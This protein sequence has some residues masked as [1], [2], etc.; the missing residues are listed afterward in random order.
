MNVQHDEGWTK[1]GKES[2]LKF[3]P[4]QYVGKP[5][6]EIGESGA[7]GKGTGIKHDS[8]KP[9]Y[10]LLPPNALHE[11]VRTLTA[12]A[13]KYDS[14]DLSI[15]PNWKKVDNPQRR[16]FAASQRH[17]WAY[18]R[19]EAYDVGEGGSDCHHLAAA[20]TNLMFLLERELTKTN[21]G[22]QQ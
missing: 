9:D 4:S 1:T 10:S 15:E 2:A 20:I 18:Q 16:F 3:D 13:K 8:G 5:T 17:Q 22:L 7:G 19:G 21:Q 12:G 11:I 6:V 14:P